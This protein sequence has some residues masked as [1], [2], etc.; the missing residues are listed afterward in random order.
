M[1]TP[2]CRS[3]SEH[4]WEDGWTHRPPLWRRPPRNMQMMNINCIFRQETGLHHKPVLTYL[5]SRRR[6]MN[7]ISQAG[8]YLMS[9]RP[10][11]AITHTP[12]PQRIRNII[13]QIST[14]H[15]GYTR[16][17]ILECAWVGFKLECDQTEFNPLNLSPIIHLIW[18][19]TTPV[20]GLY[21][22]WHLLGLGSTIH[23]K[24]SF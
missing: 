18:K 12:P 4:V 19:N 16:T 21:S 22:T 3:V 2:A 10:R 17:H 9:D 1:A 13:Q 20:K 6:V 5:R 14:T 15:P 24:H 11:V 23:R 7:S 8:L